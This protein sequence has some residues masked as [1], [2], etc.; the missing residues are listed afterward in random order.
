MVAGRPPTLEQLN[1]DVSASRQVYEVGYTIGEFAVSRGGS[2][3]LVRLVRSN[4][5]TAAVLGLS[6]SEFE[7][8]WYAF[9]REKYL[10]P[11]E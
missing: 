5:D 4:G 1:A 7:D 9:I 11:A 8:E 2:E 10:S 6:P 3:A